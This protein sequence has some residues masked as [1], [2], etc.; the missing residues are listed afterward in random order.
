M[1]RL[2]YGDIG[3]VYYDDEGRAWRVAGKRVW[4]MCSWVRLGRR[5]SARLNRTV[6]LSWERAPGLDGRR[7]E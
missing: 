7:K 5:C 4:R 6:R 3:K 1:S 2:L